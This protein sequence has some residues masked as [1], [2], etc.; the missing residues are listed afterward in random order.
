MTSDLQD[1]PEGHEPF[2]RSG[3]D[4]ALLRNM[5]QFIVNGVEFGYIQQPA[6]ESAEEGTLAKARELL[7]R[8]ATTEP[9][10]ALLRISVRELMEASEA[11]ADAL[12]DIAG[13]GHRA[14][15]DAY[16]D[17]LEAVRAALG[18]SS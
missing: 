11:V 9:E 14:Y 4:A 18:R 16:E 1:I 6:S 13:D 3:G 17:A 12:R 10:P 8:A 2:R 7:A 5:A 15:L